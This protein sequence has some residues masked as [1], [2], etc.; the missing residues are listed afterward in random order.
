MLTLNEIRQYLT[1]QVFQ[2]SAKIEG[3]DS[4]DAQVDKLL[5][6]YISAA[7][8][9][10][11]E[12]PE[13]KNNKQEKPTKET[14]KPVEQQKKSLDDIDVRELCISVANLIDNIDNLIEFKNALLRRTV[15]KLDDQYSQD[16]VRQFEIIMEDDFNM[17][18]G[19]TE[20]DLE[21]EINVPTADRA[22][23]IS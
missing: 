20:K 7:N 9:S 16:V 14:N 22:G 11:E 23:P 17:A 19:K 15:N 21:D 8:N 13:D 4:L 12:A 5:L 3:N 2:E 10:L 6:S 18:I 1:S